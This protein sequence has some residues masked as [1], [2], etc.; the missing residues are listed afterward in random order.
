MTGMLASVTSL[1]EARLC[2]AGGAD[3]IDLKNPAAGALGALPVALIAEVVRGLAGCRTVSATTGDF[4]AMTPAEVL[5]GAT[6]VAAT[7]VDYVK[8][9][10]FPAPA[11]NESIDALQT[12]AAQGARLVAVLFADLGVDFSILPRLHAAGFT[13]VMLDTARKNGQ[14]LRDVVPHA[15]LAAFLQAA[16]EYGLMT[17]LAGSLRLADIA[18]LLPLAPDYLGF[19]GALCRQHLRQQAIDPAAIFHIRQEMTVDAPA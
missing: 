15:Q 3:I 16:R 8:I 17:G 5:A 13:G 4:P 6:A 14:S 11:R 10:L 12:L 18:P 7:G 19:R 1:E 9:G 2:C